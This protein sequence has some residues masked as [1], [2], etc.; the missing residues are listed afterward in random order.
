M[1]SDVSL[2]RHA[3]FLKLWASESVSQ[4]GAQIA[5]LALP[6]TAIVT[7]DATPG[8]MGL[9]TATSSLPPLL[10]GL[11]SGAVIDR[12]ERRPIMIASDVGR[13]ILLGCVPLAWATNTLSIEILY[14][15]AFLIGTLT[16]ISSIAHQAFLPILVARQRLVDA[17]SKM[18]LTSTAAEVAGPSLA[19]GLV[20][21]FAAPLAITANAC[22]YLVSALLLSRI[23]V[24][25]PVA[26]A[27]A[28]GHG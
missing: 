25:E 26:D 10:V 5:F 3:D 14:L 23:R 11:Q 16:L 12:R 17:N 19:G 21:V 15:I 7:L 9:L 18:A 27:P 24:T 22:S 1:T 20:Q 4:I 13:A 8:Q 6:L 2:W 28:Q